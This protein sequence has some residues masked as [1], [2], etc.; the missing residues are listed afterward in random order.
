VTAPTSWCSRNE[1]STAT[2]C[3]QPSSRSTSTT[4]L[5][6][7]DVAAADLT[8]LVD[9]V[10]RAGRVAIETGTGITMSADGNVVQWLR[11]GPHDHH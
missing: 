7:A 1:P 4:L 3:G 8:A 10:R 11:V 2:R 5:A 9:A 6:S